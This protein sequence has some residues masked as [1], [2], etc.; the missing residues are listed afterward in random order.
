[1]IHAPHGETCNGKTYD[2][3]VV[4]A[5]CSDQV[6]G[7]YVV[8]DAG[9]SPHSPA[10]PIFK[11]RPRK[12]M[13][14]QLKATKSFPAVM[15]HGPVQ[16][17][18]EPPDLLAMNVMAPDDTYADLTRRTTDILR[19]LAGDDGDPRQEGKQKNW[20]EGPPLCGETL[21]TPRPAI[22]PDRLRRP[23]RGVAPPAGF[24]RSWLAGLGPRRN[25]QNGNFSSTTTA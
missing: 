21:P 14:R 24:E 12:T 18:P 10:R 17:Q 9:L 16:E 11:G 25:R 6:V 15:P 3:F 7:A 22:S 2:F 13:V 5:A 4:D 19:S 23:E 20:T 1:M 8:A